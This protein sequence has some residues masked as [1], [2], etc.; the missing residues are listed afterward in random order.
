ME[1]ESG[2][3]QLTKNNE[4]GESR[5]NIPNVRN[6]FQ[7]FWVRRNT[8]DA[9]RINWFLFRSQLDFVLPIGIV[10]WI[11]FLAFVS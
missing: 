10:L 3:E 7:P 1:S 8:D 6:V 11:I 9:N 2:P 4:E 5:N